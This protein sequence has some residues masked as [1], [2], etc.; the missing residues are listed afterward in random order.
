[1]NLLKVIVA[2]AATIVIVT[3]AAGRGIEPAIL[4]ICLYLVA[5]PFEKDDKK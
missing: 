2:F 5:N 1:M 4:F 3:F